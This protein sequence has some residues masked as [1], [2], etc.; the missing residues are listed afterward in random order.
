MRLLGSAASALSRRALRG[1]AT[2]Q[3]PSRHELL[4]IGGGTAGINVANQ[5]KAVY[6]ANDCE[7]PETTIVD[8]ADRHHYQPGWTLVGAGLANKADLNRPMSEMVPGHTTRIAQDAVNVDPESQTV[9]LGDGRVLT[10]GQLVLCPGIRINYDG[11]KG[12]R[13]AL[14]TD[15]VATI[16]DFN[17]CD[18]VYHN[19]QALENGRAV[20]THPAGDVKCAGAPQKIMWMAEDYW[21]RQ[22]R[23]AIDGKNGIEVEF[24]TNLPQMFGVKKYSDVLKGLT[25]ERGV[26]PNF[27]SVLKAV[28]SRRRIA[29]FASGAEGEEVERSFDFLHAVPPMAPHEFVKKS[30][31]AN[32]NGFVDVDQK[33]LQSTKYSNVW[34]LGDASSLATSKT[35]AAIMSQAPILAHNFYLAN[36]R[37]VD[38][39]SDASASGIAHYD[40]YTS[41]PLLTS[42][43]GL[44][45][46]EFGYGGE[47][48]ETFAKYGLSQDKPSRWAYH[49]KKDV[50]PRLY[51]GAYQNGDW[52]GR[53]AFFRPSFR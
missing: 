44:L 45:L 20:F 14:D 4:I 17:H 13:E 37:K 26:T 24:H 2:T 47:I 46:A 23:R 40:G 5:V 27:K 31:V 21:R 15:G 53:N 30:K 25:E 22:G 39:S 18:K 32:G 50:F 11:V 28:D 7:P 29:T 52:Y 19:I 42:Y 33:T 43:G 35:A 1:Y 34:S 8:G 9:T 6:L 12:L 36:E 49:L 3:T 48:K 10:Y 41:C 16:Y 51:F 38:L